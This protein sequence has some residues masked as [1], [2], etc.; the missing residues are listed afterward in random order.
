MSFEWDD[1]KDL[2]NLKKHG[3]SFSEAQE[4]FT[5]P[6]LT[7]QDTRKNYNESRY[8]TIGQLSP[9][10]TIVV[11]HTTRNNNS[12]IISARKA[13]KKERKYYHAYLKS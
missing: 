6:H 12:R 2:T 8:I 1:T 3:I 7:F 5:Q 10:A 11:V 4:I 9:K 13:N